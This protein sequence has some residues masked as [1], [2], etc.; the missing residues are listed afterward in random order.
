M[1]P[2][3]SGLGNLDLVSSIKKLAQLNAECGIPNVELK[4]RDTSTI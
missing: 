4:I 1:K 3:G 2:P